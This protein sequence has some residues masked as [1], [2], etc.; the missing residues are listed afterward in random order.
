VGWRP[1]VRPIPP[2]ANRRGAKVRK[3]NYQQ[4]LEPQPLDLALW[5]GVGLTRGFSRSLKEAGFGA[6]QHPGCVYPDILPPDFGMRVKMS[7]YD[8]DKFR[9]E[10]EQEQESFRGK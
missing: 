8:L 10:A 9:Q 6:G 4:K 7:E 2:S 5:A 1:T 3:S